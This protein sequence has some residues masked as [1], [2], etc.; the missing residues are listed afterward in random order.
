MSITLTQPKTAADYARLPEGAPV[1]LIAGEFIMTPSPSTVHQNIVGFLF[2]EISIAAKK[3]MA[4]KAYV[5][6]LDVYLSPEDIY[7][8]DIFFVS[9]QRHSMIQPNGMHG[10]PALVIEVLSASTAYYDQ[11]SKK[12]A[13][14]EAGVNEHWIVNPME[15]LI[16]LFVSIDGKFETQFLGK[17]GAVNSIVL[18]GFSIKTEDVFTL[19]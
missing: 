3:A 16:E 6:P 19:G 7:Q 9:H 14:E 15:H 2:I 12:E 11:R 17:E 1:Q 4:G 8:P 18:P 13:Y 5:A 10:A